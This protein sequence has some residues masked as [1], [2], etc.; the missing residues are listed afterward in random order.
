MKVTANLK[1]VLISIFMRILNDLTSVIFIRV[2]EENVA[3]K[4]VI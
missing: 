3:K 2:L 1:E 4:R